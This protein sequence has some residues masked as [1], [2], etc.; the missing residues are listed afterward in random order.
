MRR[1]WSWAFLEFSDTDCLLI[2]ENM[3]TCFMMYSS[4]YF[5]RQS[6]GCI[7]FLGYFFGFEKQHNLFIYILYIGVCVCAFVA[8][9]KDEILLD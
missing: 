5:N 6:N 4:L 1:Y 7:W 2:K 3:T 9:W 8:K